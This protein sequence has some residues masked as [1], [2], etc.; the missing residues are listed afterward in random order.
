MHV[1]APA[2]QIVVVPTGVTVLLGLRNPPR[3]WTSM[4]GP[5]LPGFTI[6]PFLDSLLSYRLIRQPKSILQDNHK[7]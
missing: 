7:I 4:V 2:M 3:S 1:V 6:A 5:A